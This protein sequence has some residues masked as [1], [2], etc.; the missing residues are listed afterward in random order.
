MFLHKSLRQHSP[1]M[2]PES[3][4]CFASCCFKSSSV[5]SV[6][7]TSS[8]RG[9]S[10]F[11]VAFCKKRSKSS[12]TQTCSIN[13]YRRPQHHITVIHIYKNK[14]THLLFQIDFCWT[15]LEQI[16][17]RRWRRCLQVDSSCC[18]VRLGFSDTA[19]RTLL[20]YALRWEVAHCLLQAHSSAYLS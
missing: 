1:T 4:P 9:L 15:P 14:K 5:R 16:F 7:S 13:P 3:T 19:A 10:V 17:L 12:I 2:G 18:S 11:F 8:V 20:F 6:T